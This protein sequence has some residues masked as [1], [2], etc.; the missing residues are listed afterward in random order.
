MATISGGQNLERALNEIARKLGNKPT[1][2]SVGFLEGATEANGTPVA[3]IAAI[4]EFGAP[5]RGIPPRPFFRTMV[6]AKSPEWAPALALALEKTDNDVSAAMAMMGE[7]IAGQLRESIIATNSPPNSPV[8]NLLKQRFPMGGQTFEDV[9]KARRDV[10]A[11]ATA[12]AGK[13]LVQ[14]GVMLGSVDYEVK[15]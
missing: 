6:A 5:S 13:P 10:A 3:M 4:N 11:G 7:G 1:T 14:S 9:L 12:P 15:S 2:V 8:T